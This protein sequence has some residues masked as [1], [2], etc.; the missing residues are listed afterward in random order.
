MYAVRLNAIIC[1]LVKK[2]MG[3]ALEWVTHRFVDLS[4]SLMYFSLLLESMFGVIMLMTNKWQCDM[5]FSI[6]K[7]MVKIFGNR[8][9][10]KK[11]AH[12]LMRCAYVSSISWKIKWN[13]NGIWILYKRLV[14]FWIFQSVI[15]WAVDKT[16][17]KQETKQTFG[18][19]TS[20]QL[21]FKSKWNTRFARN[22]RPVSIPWKG[23]TW[24]FEN[25]KKIIYKTVIQ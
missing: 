17:E 8:D 22:P 7:I 19:L 11:Y 21:F 2:W 1:N 10:R 9:F 25:F 15:K 18:I 20:P 3:Y 24:D 23:E 5:A 14:H 4:I 13:V 16:V 12:L 6:S